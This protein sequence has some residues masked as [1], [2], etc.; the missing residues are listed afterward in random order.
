M[1]LA[2]RYYIGVISY[3]QLMSKCRVYDLASYI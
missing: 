1:T 2:I 3:G